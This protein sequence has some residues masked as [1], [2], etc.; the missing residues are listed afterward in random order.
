MYN[1]KNVHGERRMIRVY[2]HPLFRR[3]QPE[4]IRGILRKTN[5]QKKRHVPRRDFV[6]RLVHLKPASNS[7]SEH[8]SNFDQ[9]EQHDHMDVF[10]DNNQ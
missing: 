2:A 1:F 6:P 7:T 3:D 10:G 9:Q 8:S 5:Q 4:L